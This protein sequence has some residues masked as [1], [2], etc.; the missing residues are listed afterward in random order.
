M[1]LEISK[2][3]ANRSTVQGCSYIAKI[4]QTQIGKVFW[5]LAI[6]F[7]TLLASYWSLQVTVLVTI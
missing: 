7:M 4:K 1:L 2:E 5:F 3:H 6:C